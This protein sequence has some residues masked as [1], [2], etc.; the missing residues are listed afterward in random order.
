MIGAQPLRR[1][2]ISRILL[3]VDFGPGSHQA[4]ALARMLAQ[5]YGSRLWIA[6]VV[7][8]VTA[9]DAAF[10]HSAGAIEYAEQ[11]MARFVASESWGDV[12]FQTVIRAGHLW[13]VLS[14][15]VEENGIDLIIAG[16]HGRN[17]LTKV[18]LGSAAELMV[19]NAK[20]PVLTVSPRLRQNPLDGLLRILVPLDAQS[21]P[22]SALAYTVALA[23]ENNAQV[24]FL[25]V[26]HHSAMPLD[27]PDEEP[28]DD[29]RYA[30]AMARLREI[31]PSAQH[32]RREPEIIIDSG[33]PADTIVEVAKRTG[34]D[35]IAMPVR[36]A[37]T[38]AK[39]HAPWHTAYR[40]ICHA[41]CPVL[42]LAE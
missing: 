3:P 24:V 5:Q 31:T 21:H 2:S 18:V 20:C 34:A 14:Q 9:P 35:L 11:H 36:R 8:P 30:A 40:V 7:E 19:R 33:V 26:L 6:H 37:A 29:E 39:V 25:H 13:H 1:S 17:W 15:L 22:A 32:F 27:Y 28:I 16:A 41:T 12:A 10:I 38:A 4:G 42:T 23:N